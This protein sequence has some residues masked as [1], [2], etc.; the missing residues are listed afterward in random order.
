MSFIIHKLSFDKENRNS[1]FI[2]N[3][4]EMNSNIT[5]SI[6][7]GANG[8]G[9]SLFL[10]KLIDVFQDIILSKEDMLSKRSQPD[11]YHII[12]ELDGLTYNIIKNN[13]HYKLGDNIRWKDI[14]V[15]K[16]ILAL[17]FL[18]ED[19][20]TYKS[21]DD[22]RDSVYKYLGIRSTANAIFSGATNKKIRNILFD[23]VGEKDFRD[24]IVKTFDLLGYEP[25]VKMK[26]EYI[27]KSMVTQKIGIRTIDSRINTISK[28]SKYVNKKLEML[29][30][31]DK[32]DI[33]EY[34]E[35]IRQ[36]RDKNT[37]S[38]IFTELIINFRETEQ[39]YKKYRIVK[40]MIVAG[41][42]D[43]STI[44]ISQ[45]N[46]KIDSEALSSG[47]K[48]LL[49]ITL[50]ILAN[51]ENNSLV[52]IDEPEISLH[53]NWQIKYNLHLKQILS[54][55]K[56]IHI[57]IATHS[58]FM[59][60]GLQK[61]EANIFTIHKDKSVEKIEE[62]IYSWSTE[63]ILYRIFNA[64]TVNNYYLEM[65]LKN[66]FQKIAENDLKNMTDI[67]RSYEKLKDITY[68]KDDP[69]YTLTQK[70]K[71]YIDKKQHVKFR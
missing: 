64:R 14:S 27:L 35:S 65:E 54:G 50:N 3:I 2:F 52:V 55:Y 7:I 15:P 43:P 63:N 29:T 12:Y 61:N 36:N 11:Y 41:L 17:T 34:I 32:Y 23:C 21:Q 8:T 13:G 20:F 68:H 44:E 33:L 39:S 53:P 16:S 56:N 60:S 30:R 6:I 62:N 26:F 42:L 22:N 18:S 48:N 45:K 57:I 47:E 5:F 70:I 59:V 19:K 37:K 28:K 24:K 67:I 38:K 46:S 4:D 1:D 51:I 31:E 9:K 58:H 49:F 25:I 69:L 10:A 66:V 71:N 40:N